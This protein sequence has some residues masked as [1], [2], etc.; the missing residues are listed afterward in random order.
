[1]SQPET[2]RMERVRG[3]GSGATIM[4]GFG[5]A[6][7][8]MGMAG[9]G[10]SVAVALAIVVPVFVLIAAL[11]TVARRRLPKMAG[12]ETPEKKQRMRVFA[13][14]N[15]VEW[16]AIFGTVNLLRNL[17]LEGWVIPAIVLIVGAH[18]LPLARIFQARQHRTT[19]VALM[20]CAAM[21]LVLPGSVR[22]VAECVAAGVILWVSAAGALYAAFRLAPRS[23]VAT[24][25]SVSSAGR[26]RV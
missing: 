17:H 16:L 8:A 11:G 14:V 22:D 19:G 12:A 18:F 15:V 20:L 5:A 6:W 25:G 1:M 23:G 21:A 13:V 9:A 2:F 26:A 3:A 10:V 24:S 4:G 7:L